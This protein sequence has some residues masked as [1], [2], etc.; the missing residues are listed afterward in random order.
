[1]GDA[2]SPIVLE[3]IPNS[4]KIKIS[5]S[6]FSQCIYDI[7]QSDNFQLVVMADIFISMDV[8]K[9]FKDKK[10]LFLGD[11]IMRNLYQDFV[12]LLEGL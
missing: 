10:V 12:Y 6:L 7:L 3:V 9:I 11:S 5:P 1:M 4:V 8:K 2:E